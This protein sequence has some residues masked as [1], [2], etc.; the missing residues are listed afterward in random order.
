MPYDLS[1]SY[2]HRDNARNQVRE[3]RDAILA[4]FQDFAG[5]DLRVFCRVPAPRWS[6]DR[7]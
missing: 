4:D 1:I 3:L 6:L 7:Y 2:A 5:R